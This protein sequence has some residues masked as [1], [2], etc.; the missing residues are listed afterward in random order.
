MSP[1]VFN[2]KKGCRGVTLVE[3]LVTIAVAGIATILLIDGYLYI[4]R[5]WNN[6]NNSLA[7]Q[8]E[9]FRVYE[10][11]NQVLRKSESIQIHGDEWTLC[12]PPADTLTLSLKDSVLTLT[13]GQVV[14]RQG[15]L[16]DF[17]LLPD[18]TVPFPVWR[19]SFSYKYKNMITGY[20]WRCVSMVNT[21]SGKIPEPVIP[22]ISSGL[23][24][25][26]Q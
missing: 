4:V 17:K 21:F 23:Y 2:L 12:F 8:N 1:A 3:L 25:D 16:V 9:A 7:C 19:C 13:Q 10:S 6:Y 20:A 15:V 22:A 5:I 11:V 26:N 14:P 18:N 24:W